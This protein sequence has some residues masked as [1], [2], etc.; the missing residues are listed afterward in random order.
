MVWLGQTD[1]A[2]GNQNKSPFA[3]KILSRSQVETKV[4]EL[5]IWNC[6]TN[7]SNLN[8]TV[9]EESIYGWN[10]I[11]ILRNMSNKSRRNPP[12]AGGKDTFCSP[13]AQSS[14]VSARLG[15]RFRFHARTFQAFETRSHG[16]KEFR[17]AAAGKVGDS[18]PFLLLHATICHFT[19][20]IGRSCAWMRHTPVSSKHPRI[21]NKRS[22]L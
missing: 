10:D 21:S 9:A 12:C 22:L 2:L 4:V 15:Q 7:R 1:L 18:R 16:T 14:P 13:S 5:L 17:D 11:P 3:R 8:S 19:R 6:F 20:Q